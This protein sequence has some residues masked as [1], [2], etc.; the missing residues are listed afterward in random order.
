MAVSEQVLE[1]IEQMANE[2]TSREGC[3]LYHVEFVGIGKGR[4]LRVFID[5]EGEESVGIEDC[6][7]VSKGLNLLLDVENIIPGGSYNLEVS[8]P[9]LERGLYR[10]WHFKAALGE[11]V[12]LKTQDSLAKYGITVK[13]YAKA[14]KVSGRLQGLEEEVISLDTSQGSISL[15]LSAV[16]KA[17]VVFDYDSEMGRK[18]KR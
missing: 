8:S 3:R 17:N 15:P 1:K 10:P 5:K 9:G 12:H 4:I 14:K 6:S 13:K 16:T 18:K 7:N 2:V 11:E